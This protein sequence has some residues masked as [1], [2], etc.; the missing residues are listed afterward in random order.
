MERSIDDGEIDKEGQAAR[1]RLEDHDDSFYSDNSEES[2]ELNP[3]LLN[4]MMEEESEDVEGISLLRQIF[5]DESTEE[6]RKLFHQHTLSSPSASQQSDNNHSGSSRNR[7]PKSQLGWRVWRQV[8]RNDPKRQWTAIEP[9]DDFLRLPSS[10]AV[11]RYD[12]QAQTMRY[13]LVR[14]LEHRA[15]RQELHYSTID[16]TKYGDYRYFTVV[17]APDQE[18]GL[19]LTLIE[20][21]GTIKVL[22]L[23]TTRDR[24]QVIGPS[25][26]A[27]IKPGD[28]LVGI[29]GEAFSKTLKPP[30]LQNAVR[31]IHQC[32]SPVVIHLI[33][34]ESS[35]RGGTHIASNL[36]LK[37]STSLLDSTANLDSS[38]VFSNGSSSS[39]MTPKDTMHPF[40]RVLRAKGLIQS[41]QG[42]YLGL[43]SH[44]D[45][46]PVIAWAY[47]ILFYLFRRRR[48]K[49]HSNTCP[50]QREDETMGVYLVISN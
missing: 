19:G 36:E 44:N 39:V 25:Y 21:E 15:W 10:I 49:N 40:A 35:K 3:R 27:G 33:S 48:G 11:R 50:F 47:P 2:S 1:S 29:E 23:T 6:L 37:R 17:I 5:P 32:Q 20:E 31:M 24:T 46:H 41:R 14:E 34:P 38:S 28:I 8:L 7:T 30:L 45:F 13:Q 12:E 4:S 9:P 16:D 43:N 42:E 22:G 18:L 26:E